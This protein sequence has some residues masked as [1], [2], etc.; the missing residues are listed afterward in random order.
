M[1]FIP[2][3]KATVV[4]GSDSNVYGIYLTQIAMFS[5]DDNI[6]IDAGQLNEARYVS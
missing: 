3:I 1:V 6:W 5:H 4:G 2:E